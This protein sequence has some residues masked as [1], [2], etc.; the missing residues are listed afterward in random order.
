MGGRGSSST[1][2]GKGSSPT[3]R[4]NALGITVGQ[5]ARKLDGKILN[6]A[7]DTVEQFYKDH[8]STRGMVSTIVTSNED[9]TRPSGHL[10]VTDGAAARFNP[11]ERKTKII[12]NELS[13]KDPAKLESTYKR[14]VELGRHPKNTDVSDMIYH[15]LGH[16]A[17]TQ[18]GLNTG[19][20][21]Q[22]GVIDRNAVPNQKQRLRPQ[23]EV[24]SNQIMRH[25]TSIAKRLNPEAMRGVIP[26]GEI[27]GYAMK[28]NA[29]AVAEAFT[30]VRRNGKH[31][32]PLSQAI[33]QVVDNPKKY[34]V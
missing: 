29:E 33:V 3:A 7:A 11:I 20:I 32:H 23:I 18:W 27:S 28:S 19:L 21:H 16:A 34:H 26:T 22:N 8:P 10:G 6:L 1:R 24:A 17:T 14:T 12:L 31:A 4:L 5:E 15:E 30:D 25:A 13:F 9:A 2:H